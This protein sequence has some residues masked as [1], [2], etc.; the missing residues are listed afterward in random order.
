MKPNP[1]CRC[2]FGEVIHGH[3]HPDR[4]VTDHQ[5]ELP[6]RRLQRSPGGREEREHAVRS[7]PTEQIGDVRRQ[8]VHDD[9]RVVVQSPT[10]HCRAPGGP[11]PSRSNAPSASLVRLAGH[12]DGHAPAAT[13]RTGDRPRHEC[14]LAPPVVPVGSHHDQRR[15]PH[16]PGSRSAVDTPLQVGNLRSEA[17]RA[18]GRKRRPRRRSRLPVSSSRSTRRSH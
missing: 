10:G 17:A 16:S 5:V 11:S 18:P 3:V 1:W 6:P 9:G 7:G 12:E 4:M 8:L 2:A 14:Q 15:P 13:G